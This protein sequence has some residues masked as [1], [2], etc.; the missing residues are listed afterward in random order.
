[1][2]NIYTLLGAIVLM[3]SLT[4]SSAWAVTKDE[5]KTQGLIGEQ[6][7]GYLGIVIAQ[8]GPDLK[9]LVSSINKK[10]RA[11]YDKGANKAG[12]ERAVF[13]IRMGQRLQQRAPSGHYIQLQNGNWQKK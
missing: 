6:A 7:N 9:N 1:M 11:A 5:A 12:V 2:K 3:C 13:E 10:R 8:P 4:V